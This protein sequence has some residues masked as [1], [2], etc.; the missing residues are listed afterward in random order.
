MNIAHHAQRRHTSKT[1]DPNR[2]IPEA[3][4]NELQTLLRFSPSSVN[5]QP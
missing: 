4:I 1:F 3:T 5:S 2:T